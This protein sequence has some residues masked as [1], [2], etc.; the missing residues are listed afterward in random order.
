MQK[1]A[2]ITRKLKK[3]MESKKKYVQIRKPSFTKL[4]II[5]LVNEVFIYLS[6]TLLRKLKS[7]SS[8]KSNKM[9]QSVF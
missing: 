7:Y 5:I 2:A 3:E 9:A 4:D 1:Q 8:L 6:V